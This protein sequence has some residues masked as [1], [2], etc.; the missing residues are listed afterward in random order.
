MQVGCKELTV[1]RL[2]GSIWSWG[3]INQPPMATGML[4]EP[5]G[6]I[7]NGHPENEVFWTF[8]DGILAIYNSRRRLMWLFEIIFL[9]QGKFSL[10]SAPHDDLK[11][12]TFFCLQEE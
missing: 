10:V 6:R 1:E 11:W 8:Y 5:D 4:L 3:E 9:D 7:K 12:N 2:I